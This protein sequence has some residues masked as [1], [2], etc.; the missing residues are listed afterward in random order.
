M[1][2][3]R[4]HVLRSNAAVHPFSRELSWFHSL[5]N[6]NPSYVE[7]RCKIYIKNADCSKNIRKEGRGINCC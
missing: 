6:V 5:L 1:H 2:N 3:G 4:V 7:G